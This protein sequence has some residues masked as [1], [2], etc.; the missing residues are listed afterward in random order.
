MPRY[1][2][3]RK[4][5]Q[6]AQ[7]LLQVVG[8]MQESSPVWEYLKKQA[9]DQYE[10]GR[11]HKHKLRA[12]SSP[13]NAART[14]LH[15]LHKHQRGEEIGGGITE[16]IKWAFEATRIPAA[17]AKLLPDKYTHNELTK[18]QKQVA[19]ALDLTYK[20]VDERPA[21]VG[22]LVRLPEYDSDRCS[23][24]KQPDGDYLVTVH[25]T[26]PTAS[27]LWSDAKIAAGATEIH[28][29]EVEKLLQKLNEQGHRFDIAGHSLGTQFIQSSEKLENADEIYLFNPASSPCQDTELLE[30]RANDDRYTYFVNPSDLVSDGLFQQMSSEKMN[31]DYVG[32]AKLSPLA[33]HTLEQWY[34]DLPDEDEN[35]PEE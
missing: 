19:K 10:I 25:G 20:A 33:A 31:S 18:R 17:L 2:K 35:E 22:G 12:L 14:V 15:E 24:W 4:R 29:E 11:F 34:G 5:L 23:V 21:K 13:Q 9:D 16:F 1:R 6:D 7:H 26:V 28:N 27:D 30:N 32:H 8:R 3:R